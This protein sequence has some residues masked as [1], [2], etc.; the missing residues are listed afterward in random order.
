[1]DTSTDAGGRLRFGAFELD[2]RSREL[3][4]GDRLVRLQ[5]QPF[6]IL[7]MMLER[8]GDVVTRDELRH[9]L[10]PDGTFVAAE[11]RFEP[12]R[13]DARYGRLLELLC[14]T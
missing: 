9:R 8:P 1:M 11:P 4:R 2:I 14:L 3:R 5:E 6:E 12:I 10:W 7:R 13:A